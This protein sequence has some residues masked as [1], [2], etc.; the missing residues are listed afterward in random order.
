MWE[1]LTGMFQAFSLFITIVGVFY[2]FGLIIGCA[3]EHFKDG[4]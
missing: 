3:I 4:E 2:V 1:F